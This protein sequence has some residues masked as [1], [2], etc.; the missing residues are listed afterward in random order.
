M[1]YPHG[2]GR[3]SI[4]QESLAVAHELKQQVISF[5]PPGMFNTTRPQ[6]SMASKLRHS[7][8]WGRRGNWLTGRDLHK[9]RR[10]SA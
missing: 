1:P 7:A 5:D 9:P 2:F 4:V 6:V 10:I 3:A 8:N